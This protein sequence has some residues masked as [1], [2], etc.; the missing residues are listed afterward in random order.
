MRIVGGLRKDLVTGARGRDRLHEHERV[1]RIRGPARVGDPLAVWRKRRCRACRRLHVVEPRGL[2][3]WRVHPER[4][5]QSVDHGKCE[6]FTRSRPRIRNVFGVR[7]GLRE[8]FSRARAVSALRESPGPLLDRIGRQS[9]VHR[10]TRLGTD[11]FHRTSAGE[12]RCF[13]QDRTSTRSPPYHLPSQ[14]RGVCRRGRRAGTRTR[15]A[16][17]AAGSCR[18]HGQ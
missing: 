17:G 2:A 7:L 15:H 3:I 11:C 18:Q 14:R 4:E 5:V 13:R 12:S 1:A 6:R 8:P 10:Q 9:V 16:E